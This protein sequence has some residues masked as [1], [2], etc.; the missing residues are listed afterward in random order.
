MKTALLILAA[1]LC[2]G[3]QPAQA[4][5]GAQNI[6]PSSNLTNQVAFLPVVTGVYLNINGQPFYFGEYAQSGDS[7]IVYP[8]STWE[9]KSNGQ[10]I[11]HGY[12]RVSSRLYQWAC[13]RFGC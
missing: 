7:G 3:L 12:G 10:V 1:F 13:Q 11:A 2:A 8:G 4:A 6:A 9:I 5:I